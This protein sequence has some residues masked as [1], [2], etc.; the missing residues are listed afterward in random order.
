MAG[1]DWATTILLTEA[2]GIGAGV[3][4]M[5][6]T[7]AVPAVAVLGAT[8]GEMA[9]L[10]AGVAARPGLEV[11][12]AIGADMAHKATHGAKVV[13]VNCYAQALGVVDVGSLSVE[14]SWRIRVR[15]GRPSCC[16]S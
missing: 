4:V 5:S 11:L 16:A 9:I 1:W 6:P 12:V 13:H 15:S 10:V 2:M 14:L 3:T 8:G 7:I